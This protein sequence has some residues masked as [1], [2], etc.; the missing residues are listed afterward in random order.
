M[1]ILVD[2]DACPVKEEVVRVAKKYKIDVTM[3][4]DTS[5]VY[6]DGYSTV[7][8]VD[9]ADDSVDFKIINKAVLGDIVVTQD[10]GLAS[11]S[12]GKGCKV[13][14]QNGFL[15][16]VDNIDRMLFERHL[17]KKIRQSGGRGGHIK[18]RTK[19]NDEQFEIGFEELVKSL[20]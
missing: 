1:K 9:R 5:H 19:E 20:L 17:S 4:I 10:Y 8:T 14:H 6:K 12:L 15:Y 16:T 3:V 18:K 7:I 11:M 13:I 2:A